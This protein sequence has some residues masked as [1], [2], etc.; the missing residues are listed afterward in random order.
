LT[1]IVRASA[2][3]EK[4]LR[5]LDR[6]VQRRIVEYLRTR[7]AGDQDPRRFGK[8]LRGERAG[9]WRYRV[10]DY[11]LIC[12]IDDVRAEVLVL[13]IGHRREIYR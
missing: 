1:W 4:H 2:T 11:R 12:R 3:A 6:Q 10:G 5:Q 7:V 9:L 8:A 13:A